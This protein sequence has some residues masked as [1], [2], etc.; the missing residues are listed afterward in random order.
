M[1]RTTAALF[2]AALTSAAAQSHPHDRLQQQAFIE[3]HPHAVSLRLLIVPTATIGSRLAELVDTNGD[4]RLSS[5]E[6]LAFATEVLRDTNPSVD[7]QTAAIAHAR[8]S[9]PPYSTLHAG[10]GQILVQAE[11]AVELSSERGNVIDFDVQYDG[12]SPNWQVQPFY[13]LSLLAIDPEPE[14]SRTRNGVSVAVGR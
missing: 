5:S 2:A 11:V 10:Q 4:E 9:M 1:M 3:I 14:M 6:N 13:A 12:M 7:G 8:I